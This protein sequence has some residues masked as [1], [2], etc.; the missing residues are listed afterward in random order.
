MGMTAEVRT[1]RVFIR[2]WRNQ[3]QRARLRDR[4][5]RDLRNSSTC[6]AG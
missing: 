2:T 4:R 6:L 1:V 3:A 5:S